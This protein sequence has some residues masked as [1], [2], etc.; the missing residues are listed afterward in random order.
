MTHLVIQLL[1]TSAQIPFEPNF[2]KGPNLNGDYLLS[3]TPGAKE[4]QKRFPTHFR[5]YPGGV[6]SFDIYSPVFSTRYSQVN[7]ELSQVLLAI[8]IACKAIAATVREGRYLRQESCN[9]GDVI[10][11]TSAAHE[12]F[13]E[14]CR[15]CAPIRLLVSEHSEAT[16]L[17]SHDVSTLCHV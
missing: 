4:T 15:Q 8:Q 17:L 16:T 12:H 10:N 5:D 11:L 7:A 6:E 9:A 2:T 1:A 14:Q 13:V 3:P